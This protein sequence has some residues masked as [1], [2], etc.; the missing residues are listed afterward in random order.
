MSAKRTTR[1][2]DV[3]WHVV[4]VDSTGKRQDHIVRGGDAGTHRLVIARCGGRA[5]SVRRVAE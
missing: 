1:P 5:I 2:G 3:Q 4:Y